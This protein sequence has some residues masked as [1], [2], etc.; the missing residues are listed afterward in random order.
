MVRKGSSNVL[1]TVVVMTE[2]GFG[3]PARGRVRL[4]EPVDEAPLRVEV[5]EVCFPPNIWQLLEETDEG[6][7]YFFRAFDAKKVSRI[8]DY[9]EEFD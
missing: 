5:G 8:D 2:P 7:V 4:K 9:L 1:G 6:F 3:W